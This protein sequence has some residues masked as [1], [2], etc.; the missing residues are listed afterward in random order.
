MK[1]N[2]VSY[3]WTIQGALGAG[4]EACVR[5]ADSCVITWLN[6]ALSLSAVLNLQ[7]TMPEVCCRLQRPVKEYRLFV[8]GCVTT[9][10]Q[11]EKKKRKKKRFGGWNVMWTVGFN[12][13]TPQGCYRLP[14]MLLK[15]KGSFRASGL[16][17][18]STWPCERPRFPQTTKTEWIY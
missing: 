15:A 14:P 18:Y 10:K 12:H 2:V 7:P 17:C 8:I 9:A 3:Q 11:E 4:C 1:N 6:A 5:A 16:C 13:W